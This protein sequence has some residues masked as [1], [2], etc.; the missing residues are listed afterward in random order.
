MEWKL[1]PVEPTPAMID[2]AGMGW[3][4]KPDNLKKRLRVYDAMVSAAPT[5]PHDTITGDE[6]RVFQ[7]WGGMDGAVAFHL[8]ERHANGW[9]DIGKMMAAWLEANRGHEK[10]PNV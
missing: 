7:N 9:G 6:A 4:V 5:A 3:I 2:A 10:T 1:V 8:I